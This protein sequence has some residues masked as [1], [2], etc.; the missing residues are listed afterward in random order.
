MFLFMVVF[1]KM[2]KKNA[3]EKRVVPKPSGGIGRQFKKGKGTRN[4]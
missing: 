4:S 3:K 1:D 2:K